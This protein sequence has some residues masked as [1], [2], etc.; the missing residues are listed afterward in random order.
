MKPLASISLDLDNKWAYLKAHGDPQWESYPTYF[1]MIVPRV[2]DILEQRKQKITFFV[3]GQD[4][5]HEINR[6]P[7]KAIADAG[8]E[9]A[10]HSYNHEPWLHLY[11][12]KQL[13]EEFD[14]SEAAIENA[15]GQVPIGFRGPGFSLSDEVLRTLM[16]RGY[17]YDG[18]SFPTF[19]G[20]VARAYYFWSSGL[21]K[22]QKEDRKELF[23]RFTD[24]FKTLAPYRFSWRGRNIVEMPVTTMPIFRLP[25]HGSYLLF[26]GQ[27]S[28]WLAKFYFRF[29]L[30]L[31]KLTSVEPHFLLHPLD[32]MGV[33]DDEDMVFFPTMDEPSSKKIKLIT[34]CID[35]LKREFN[36]VTMRDHVAQARRQELPASTISV[37]PEGAR[38]DMA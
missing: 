17:Q 22:D 2:L 19:L 11:G 36:V 13:Q 30:K 27:Y 35:I 31:C 29:A 21:S 4:A 26:L 18:T 14:K 8:H 23:G 7:L 12:P 24:G 9:I 38:A 5:E 10:N 6:A 3:V 37:V 34:E 33:E 32:F 16:R 25:I 28:T 1:P 15:T 20:P